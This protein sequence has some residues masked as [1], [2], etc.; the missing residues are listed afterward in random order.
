M[1]TVPEK[2]H[3]H[4]AKFGTGEKAEVEES[5]VSVTYEDTPN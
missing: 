3:I 4:H 1:G 2:W 5:L